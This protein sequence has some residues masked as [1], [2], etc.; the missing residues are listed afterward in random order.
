MPPQLTFHGSV[1]D[2]PLTEAPPTPIKLVVLQAMAE[3]CVYEDD[4]SPA[5]KNERT[6]KDDLTCIGESLYITCI[7]LCICV[8]SHAIYI[9]IFLSLYI[10][11]FIY[12]YIY[13]HK[14]NQ[15]WDLTLSAPDTTTSR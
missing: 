1:A 11:L 2:D 8:F 6:N 10:Y 4:D 5:G 13:I 12:L 3:G 14:Y 7:R 15:T 9:Y